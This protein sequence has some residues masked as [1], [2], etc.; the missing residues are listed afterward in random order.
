ML[1][2]EV[3]AKGFRERFK[4]EP[5]VAAAPGRVNLIGEHTD[6]NEGFVLPVAIDRAVLVAAAPSGGRTFRLYSFDFRES[7]EFEP[8]NLVRTK[9]APWANYVMGVVQEM[10]AAGIHVPGACLGIAGD[11]PRGAGL[12][13]SAALEVAC[14]TAL[15]ALA[16]ARVEPVEL[17]RICHRAENNFVGVR[18]GIMD[19]FVSA[20]GQAGHA[21]LLDCRSETWEQIPLSLPGCV[22]VVSN[23]LVKRSLASS[24]YNERR[25][26]CEEAVSLLRGLLPGVSALRDVSSRDLVEK[27]AS[28]PERLLR[29]A[30]HV[31]T[32]N[33]RTL[34]AAR[35]MREGDLD[36]LG[37][38]L[39]ASHES[40]RR[41][42]E[43]S[44]PELDRLVELARAVPGV[45]GSRM[46]GAGFGGCTVS[47]VREEALADFTRTVSSGYQDIF[48]VRPEI[49]PCRAEQGA[50]LLRRPS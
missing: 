21:L 31:V 43:V 50:R 11:V 22:L 30:R 37:E 26:E 18:C 34:A 39:Y 4:A 23:T 24:K 25:A 6:Y 5:L 17:G 3:V 8:D 42:Y 16:D 7:F 36:R 35:A 46:T 28:L 15:A 2:P 48:G 33:E 10:T 40:L 13:S 20:L 14:A 1:D 45:V 47:I 38:L 32:E 27:G 12:S 29:R 9:Y 41:D 19:Q 44:C 49:Y